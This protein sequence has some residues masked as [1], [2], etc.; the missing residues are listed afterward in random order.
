MTYRNNLITESKQLSMPKSQKTELIYRTTDP[1]EKVIFT[2]R[3]EKVILDFDLAITYGVPTKALN[4]A[5]KRNADRFPEDFCF[6][7]TA[8]EW[9][10][11]RSQFVTASK[12][13][14]RHLPQA[15]T[16]Q[17]AIMAANVLH[18]PWAM[19]MSVFVVRAFVKLRQ[20]LG[21]NRQ[22]AEKLAELE[23]KLSDRLDLHE[24]AILHLLRRMQDLL[25]P[26]TGPEP[27]KKEIGFQVRERRAVYR[28]K[29]RQQSADNSTHSKERK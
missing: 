10:A 23:R 18:S 4:Q 26:P 2:V 20:E 13:N 8:L 29:R 6:Q 5:V 17:G 7:L 16:E 21:Q 11:M 28:V 14:F 27:P 22:F 3:G 19:K 1:I 9:E 15:F 12:R 24:Q 25:N